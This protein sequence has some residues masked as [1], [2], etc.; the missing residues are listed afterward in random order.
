MN[1]RSRD[2]LIS[3]LAVVGGIIGLIL[4]EV[5]DSETYP[6]LSRFGLQDWTVQC[7]GQG[8]TYH[9]RSFNPLGPNSTK[10]ITDRSLSFLDKNNKRSYILH[11]FD[12]RS[13][14]KDSVW[15]FHY[16][17]GLIKAH[18]EEEKAKVLKGDEQIFEIAENFQSLTVITKEDKKLTLSCQP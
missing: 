12:K 15:R 11:K 8:R 7:Q 10:H 6:K 4:I 2:I 17:E 18:S 13:L 5:Y 1:K 3:I 16:S 14:D 9:L